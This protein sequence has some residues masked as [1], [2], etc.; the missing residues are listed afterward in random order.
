[1]AP[2]FRKINA[3][4]APGLEI[5]DTPDQP[6]LEGGPFINITLLSQNRLIE[7]DFDAA[8]NPIASNHPTAVDHLF[9]YT[10]REWDA[11]AQLQYN[12]ARWDDAHAE[13]WLSED[14]IGFEA[15]DPNLYRYVG[16]SAISQTD[17]NGRVIDYGRDDL[18]RQT[19][20]TW[21]RPLNMAKHY[22]KVRERL[23]FALSQSG[24]SL[25]SK[26]LNAPP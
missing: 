4:Y 2:P 19:T 8:G 1:M 3:R 20:E 21:Y 15:G 11:D 17:R 5:R 18:L 9:G 7:S 10:G 12:R 6:F 24:G 26:L 22:T 13:R 25:G 14:P 16:N 23:R